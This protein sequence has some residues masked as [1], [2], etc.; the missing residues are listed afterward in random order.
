MAKCGKKM[1]R[2]GRKPIFIP[3]GVTVTNRKGVVTVTG[4]QGQL[5]QAIRPEV[6]VSVEGNQVTVKRLADDK[7][8]RS[9]HG[10]IRSL[11]ANMV[12]GVK[13]G[14][15][16]TLELVGTGYRVN[17]EGETAV[18]SLGFSHPVQFVAPEGI[19]L[20]VEANNVV[21]V[22]GIDKVLVGQVAANI[23]ALR[24]PEPYKGKGIR[25]QGEVVKTKPGKAGKVGA[26]GGFGTG[27]GQ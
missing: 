16:K 3:E 8:S 27:G 9:L 20:T 24:P 19:K 22:S 4:P 26:A 15:S 13:G 7:L 2:I 5:E 17:L 25:Y 23:R 11:L 21:I 1:S 14:F 12:Q 10:S 6:I 18:F